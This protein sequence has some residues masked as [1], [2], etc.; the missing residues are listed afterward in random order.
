MGVGRLLS[1][2]KAYFQSELLVLGRIHLGNVF[3][4]IILY[5][6]T[7]KTRLFTPCPVL[8]CFVTMVWNKYKT[9]ES[10]LMVMYYDRKC[11]TKHMTF[12]KSNILHIL[13]HPQ[14]SNIAPQ[15]DSVFLRMVT[16]QSFW[17]YKSQ[18][19]STNLSPENHRIS[20]GFKKR[21]CK[22][23]AIVFPTR[24]CKNLIIH[25]GC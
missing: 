10:H 6:Q 5:L 17:S 22:C 16:V 2:W 7:C 24:I 8:L 14:E 3:F 4:L 21:A 9:T 18:D 1:F 11:S 23:I 20:F 25:I 19:T 12:K 15:N 13:L